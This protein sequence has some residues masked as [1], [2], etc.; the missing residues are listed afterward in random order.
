GAKV[1]LGSATPSLESYYQATS[2]RYGLVE[3]MQRYQGMELPRVQLID[4]RRDKSSAGAIYSHSLIEAIRETLDRKK[5]VIIFRNRRGYAPVMKCAVCGWV[6]ECSQC[7]VSMTYHKHRNVL[8]CHLCGATQGMPAF[9]PACS[10]PKLVLEGYGTEKIEDELAVIFPEARI[11]RM[12]AETTRGKHTMEQL[13][14]NFEH[15]KLDILVGTQM[16]TKG[17]DFDHVGLVGVIQADQALAFPDFR[18]A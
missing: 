15:G 12:D 3:I 5:Q 1:L 2:G 9:C 16:V 18:A 14:W 6:A 8:S 13:I 11:A 4:Q 10:S 17:L 7:D